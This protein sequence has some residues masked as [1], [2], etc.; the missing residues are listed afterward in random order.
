MKNSQL[1]KIKEASINLSQKSE[2]E[3]NRFLECLSRVILE[4]K[5]EILL[6]NKRDVCLAK[7]PSAGSGQ[8][9]SEEAFVQRLVLDEKGIE[10]MIDRI[11]NLIKLRGPVGITLEEKVLNNGIILKKV[12]VAL[13]VILVIYE[14]RPEVTVDIAALCIKSGNGVILK[15]GSEAENTNNALFACIRDALLKSCFSSEM[16]SHVTNKKET[17]HLL[18]QNKFIDLVIARGG[19][20]MVKDVQSKSKIPVLAHSVGGARIYVDDSADLKK[21]T[22]ILLNAKT[23][24]PSACNSL[25]TVLIHKNISKEFTKKLVKQFQSV[26]VRIVNNW[27]KE[28]LGLTVGIKIV[29]DVDDAVLFVQKYSKKHSEGI[30]AENKKAIEKFVSSIDSAA[31]FVN[32]STRFHDGFEFGMGTEM[33]IA[34]GKLHARGPVG[35]REL[36]TYK[37]VAGGKGQIRI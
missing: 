22:K 31:V 5:D 1:K 23:S 2:K 6:A 26:G 27:R 17:L 9:S 18:Q 11:Q 7:D 13:G 32:C 8:A 36:T 21:A 34:T 15:G 12:S 24:K 14:S 10:A 30:I 29:E 16:V 25:D 4:R 33:G 35:L 3:K 28:F 37:W 20:E 19:Y